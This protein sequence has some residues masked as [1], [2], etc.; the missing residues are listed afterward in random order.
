MKKLIALIALAALPVFA[1]TN[2][3]A[4]KWFE[5]SQSV[6]DSKNLTLAVFP[7]YAP[8]L[9][10]DGKDDRWGVGAMVAYTFAGDVGQHLFT[11]LKVNYLN[12]DIWTSTVNGG[13]KADMILF[14]LPVTGITY[15][16]V[17]K[18]SGVEDDDVQFVAGA[19]LV[20]H[21]WSNEAKTI[22][23]GIGGAVEYWDKLDGPVYNLGPVVTFKW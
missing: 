9:M 22:S 20:A 15:A 18:A 2:E 8:E 14:N 1:Q 7:S 16:G 6:S 21:L 23:V 4:F 17:A 5:F 11:G 12:S 13:L 3:N 10:K 19:G